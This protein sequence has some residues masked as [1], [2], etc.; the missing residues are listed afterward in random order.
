LNEFN[1]T[2]EKSDDNL[3]NLSIKCDEIVG[4]DEFN[5]FKPEG[6]PGIRAKGKL[7]EALAEGVGAAS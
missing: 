4:E 2:F 3:G 7:S 5:S 6:K 1:D